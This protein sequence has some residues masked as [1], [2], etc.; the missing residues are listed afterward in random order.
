[1]ANPKT[2]ISRLGDRLT[3]KSTGTVSSVT[4]QTYL[5]LPDGEL[6]FLRR[7]GHL[8]QRAE[9]TAHNRS[10]I[11]GPP[12]SQE[13]LDLLAE[14]R[15]LTESHMAYLEGYGRAEIPQP[16]IPG[17]DMLSACPEPS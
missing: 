16:A 6:D 11:V 4:E 7:L 14:I 9:R 13:H 17:D 15:A 3:E 10:N 8:A 1:M 12:P 5:S 2:G